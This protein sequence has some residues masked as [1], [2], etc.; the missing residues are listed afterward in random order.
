MF[1]CQGLA[2][3]TLKITEI[4]L[5][6]IKVKQTV[7][8]DHNIKNMFSLTAITL[9]SDMLL[10]LLYYFFKNAVGDFSDCTTP[11]KKKNQYLLYS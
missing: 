10:L 7:F 1:I 8:L 5:L 9:A 6:L 4:K 11:N 3:S 2:F